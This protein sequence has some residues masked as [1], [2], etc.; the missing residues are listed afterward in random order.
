MAKMTLLELLKH[1][2]E[3]KALAQEIECPVSNPMGVRFDSLVGLELVDYDHDGYKLR[4]INEYLRTIDGQ[5]HSF[6]DYH[7]VD[8]E[9]IVGDDMRPI[10]RLRVIGDRAYL[11]EFDFEI[12]MASGAEL[13]DILKDTN[14]TSE[15]NAPIGDEERK[16]NR[17]GGLSK[18]W[19][20]NVK[21]LVDANRDG[22]ITATDPVIEKKIEYWDFSRTME[23]GFGGRKIEEFMFAEVDWASCDIT[24]WTAVEIDPSS[25]VII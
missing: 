12:D 23:N 5:K 6:T 25:V 7:L 13:Y 4:S 19:T 16:Y 17:V 15:F 2:N 24:L 3:Q 22:K 9:G 20:A 18:P 8:R 14:R 21:M 1:K 11:L 10:L